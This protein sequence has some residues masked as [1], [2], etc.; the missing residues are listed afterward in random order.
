MPRLIAS[1]VAGYAVMAVILMALFFVLVVAGAFGADPRNAPELPGTPIILLILAIGILAAAV[2]AVVTTIVARQGHA[3]A[4]LG[5]ILL[6]L[7]LWVV[8]SFG[9]NDEP[10]LLRFG[11]LVTGITGIVLGWRFELR[12]RQLRELRAD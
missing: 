2:G 12:R 11:N 9:Q 10:L 7:L 1:V 5:L 8:S 3:R 6:V 4:I